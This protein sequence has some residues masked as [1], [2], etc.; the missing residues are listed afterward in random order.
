MSNLPKYEAYQLSD[1]SFSEIDAIQNKLNTQN[2]ITIEEAYRNHRITE[3][4]RDYA[5][6]FFRDGMGIYRE[7]YRALYETF[8]QPEN[9]CSFDPLT[10][11]VKTDDNGQPINYGLKVVTPF[12]NTRLEYQD[13]NNNPIFVIFPKIK[14]AER[15]IEKLEKE[16]RYEYFSAMKKALDKMF[17]DDDRE[18]FREAISNIP[19]NTSKLHDILRLTIT[20]K[21]F[22]DVERIKRKLSEN[23]S[24]FFYINPEETRDRFLKPLSQ[25]DKRYYDIKMIMHLQDKDN[26]NF[27]VE[28]QLKIDSLFQGD[29][30]THKIYE[31][32]RQLEAQLRDNNRQRTDIETKQL[33]ARI[34]ILNNRCRQIN[35]N[36]IH[37][38]NMMVI[39]K[40]RRIEDDGYRPLRITPEFADGTYKRCRNFIA[41]EYIV[42][43]LDNI[44]KGEMFSS[45]EEINKLCYL[46][47]IKKLAPDFDEFA[48]DASAKINKHFSAL[49]PAELDRFNGINEVSERYQGVI[50]RRI[51][52][53]RLSE[54]NTAPTSNLRNAKYNSK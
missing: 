49:T 34:Q 11:A 12:V 8:G 38:Y 16:Y 5:L 20:C 33:M 6:M 32:V 50:A 23:K 2:I 17:V 25:N 54:Q 39:D 40:A 10:G 45:K 1:M 15:T 51:N 37:Q 7:V 28:V 14:S 24:D 36:A 42:E 18:N 31:Q 4:E 30:R 47:M 19:S 9:T 22:S 52:E 48:P 46:R 21:Y 35:Q 27:D 44:E 29:L 43:S 3:E 26:R 13:K 41:S 53:K